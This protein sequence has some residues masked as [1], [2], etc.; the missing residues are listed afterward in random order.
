M[1]DPILDSLRAAL[2]TRPDDIALRMALAR[3]MQESGDLAGA[4]AEAAEVLRLD[5]GCQEAR[6]F[7][8]TALSAPPPAAPAAPSAPA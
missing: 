3:R 6:D 2:E 4:M 8:L 1:T 5:A 7:M